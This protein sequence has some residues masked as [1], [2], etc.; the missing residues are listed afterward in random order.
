MFS[1]EL[2]KACIYKFHTACDKSAIIYSVC[3][4]CGLLVTAW[5]ERTP[6]ALRQRS[7]L[8]Q[9]QYQKQM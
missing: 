4:S 7:L 5:A 2:Y 1:L 9:W 3:S 6:K 8:E